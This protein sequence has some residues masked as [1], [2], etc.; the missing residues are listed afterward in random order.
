MTKS[1]LCD[2]LRQVWG[3]PC[4]FVVVQEEAVQVLQLAEDALADLVRVEPVVEQHE[5]DQVGGVVEHPVPDARDL[6][7]L[8]VDVLDVGGDVRDM[9]EVSTVTVHRRGVARWAVTLQGAV[10]VLGPPAEGLPPPTQ[11]GQPLAV[12]LTDA[13]IHYCHSEKEHRCPHDP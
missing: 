11:L 9:L 6:V 2:G 5:P 1:Q 4:E 7:V 13:Q 3:H 12:M 8:Q 10:R